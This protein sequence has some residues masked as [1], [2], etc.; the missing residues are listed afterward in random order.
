MEETGMTTG[1]CPPRWNGFFSV[2]F[3]SV[4]ASPHPCNTSMVIC[5]YL[6]PSVV[7]RLLPNSNSNLALP[8]HSRWH[9]TL[10][11]TSYVVYI[12]Q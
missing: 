12:P 10:T 9:W 3:L 7:K 2:F 4:S 5:A 6:C 1:G 11:E 8:Y